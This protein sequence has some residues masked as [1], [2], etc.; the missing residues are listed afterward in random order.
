MIYLFTWNSNFLVKQQVKVWKDHFIS[1][2]WDFNLI[3]IKNFDLIDNNFLTFNITSV[4][5]LAERKL[6]IIDIED[7]I[8]PTKS[9]KIKK[10]DVLKEERGE[11]LINILSKVPES[12]IILINM[13]NPD[14]RSKFYK[15]LS[16]I[17]ELKEF[18]KSDNNFSLLQLIS[19]KYNN[20]ISKQAIETIIA[21]KSSN[22]GK[23]YSEIEKLL[24]TY[25]YIDKKE[26]VENIVPELEESI[27]QIIDDIL[28]KRINDSIIKINIILNNINIYAFYNNLISN[29]RTSIY[30]YHLK[31]LWK[32]TGEISTI[33]DLGKIAFLITKNH[34]IEYKNLKKI[35][36]NL[37]NIDKKMKLWGLVWTEESDFKFEI[38]KE[39]LK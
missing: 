26:I 1:K 32:N 8:K 35:Y 6:V 36:I 20:K 9:K 11:L 14:K 30:I 39:L 29:L 12:N 16:K 15:S 17:A 24:I 25:N 37:V 2:Y 19:K 31:Y 13:V 33:L 5:F 4:A 7:S 28:W 3:H 34:K 22:I 10:S 23:I 27:F 38:E 21:Y 18:N